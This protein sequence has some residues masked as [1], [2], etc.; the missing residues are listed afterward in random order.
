M[1]STFLKFKQ[2]KLGHLL[3]SI[4]NKN[5]KFKIVKTERILKY[6]IIYSKNRLFEYISLAK[7]I[8]TFSVVILHTN[9]AFW[10]FNYNNYKTYWISANIIESIFYFAVPFFVLCIGATLL[11]FNERYGLKKYCYR[12]IVKVVIPLISWNILLYIFRVYIIRNMNKETINFKNLWNIYFDNKVY[13][14]FGSFHI[15]LLTYM[16]IPL[17]AYVE[18][19][20]KIK[21]YSYCFITLLITQGLSP[22][23][24]SLI[25]PNLIWPYKI[26]IGYI[27]YIVAGYIIENYRFN[28]ILKLLIYLLGIISLLIHIIG[29]KI[30]TIRYKKVITLHKGYLNLPCIIY[31]CSLFLLLKEYN[32][33]LF[34]IFDKKIINKIGS[35]TI[36]PFFIHLPVIDLC[37]NIFK[38]NI[39]SFSYRLFGGII[40]TII[41]LI[42]TFFLKKLPLIK[43]LVP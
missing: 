10:G 7:I 39:F 6:N 11:D 30:L 1:K 26:Q 3:N 15:F 21:I 12:R 18:K 22:Y 34:K 29:T 13:L 16:I 42:I 33:L 2:T 35:L 19:P 25:S 8:A 32:Y 36:G 43:Y 28:F 31:S 4:N 14:I 41:C 27:I 9:G 20:K 40:I 23:L 38:I 37:R 17:L 24:I 5:E